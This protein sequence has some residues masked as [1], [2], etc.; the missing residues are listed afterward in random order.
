MKNVLVWT[1]LNTLNLHLYIYIVIFTCFVPKLFVCSKVQYIVQLFL[2]IARR[3][4]IMLLLKLCSQTR[5][6]SKTASVVRKTL[7]TPHLFTLKTYLLKMFSVIG[8]WS[9]AKLKLVIKPALSKAE[10]THVSVSMY[11]LMVALSSSSLRSVSAAG[12]VLCVY[13]CV[14][15]EWAPSFSFPL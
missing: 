6:C 4:T 8:V 5:S 7:L 2:I 10:N 9:W 1:D 15:Q 11:G 3:A 14:Q 13:L 12:P